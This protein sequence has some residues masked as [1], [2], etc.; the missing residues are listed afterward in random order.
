MPL[1]P[2][3]VVCIS[4][5][6]TLHDELDM[7]EGDI[8][9]HSGDFSGY[10]NHK[11]LQS[12]N[13]WFGTLPY[14]R[15]FLVPG[16]HDGQFVDSY[17]DSIRMMSNATVLIDEAAE[18]EGYK[19]YGSPWCTQFGDW[20]FM[21]NEKALKEAWAK[22]PTDTGILITHQPPYMLLDT[23]LRG[24]VGCKNLRAEVL[25]RIKPKL[26]VFGHLHW[27]GGK[28]LEENGTIFVN[29]A[30]C[31]ESYEVHRKPVV[32]SLG[33]KTKM[34]KLVELTEA[35]GGYDKELDLT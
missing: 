15:I 25:N 26:H 18:Y 28:T 10:S 31:D 20:W 23:V 11:E 12:I 30:M 3:K 5:T 7:P 21:T 13:A 27:D 8:L 32:I 14:K 35:L 34:Q 19:I 16:N 4:D 24:N 29:A 1:P 17:E 33:E 9:I 22:I 2:L 6:H